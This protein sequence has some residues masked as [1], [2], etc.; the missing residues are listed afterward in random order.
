MKVVAT[1]ATTATKR[2]QVVVVGGQRRRQGGSLERR[3]GKPGRPVALAPLRPG[4]HTRTWAHGAHFSVGSGM[5]AAFETIQ[6]Q[7][8]VAPSA[9]DVLCTAVA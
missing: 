4:T 9:R 8:R 7:S 5:G 1:T 6:V 2:V 3:R